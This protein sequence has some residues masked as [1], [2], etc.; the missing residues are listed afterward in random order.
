[1]TDNSHKADSKEE[2][3]VD[4]DKNSTSGRTSSTRQC[5][6]GKE[7]TNLERYTLLWCDAQVNATDDNGQ[8][9][10]ELR[11]IINFF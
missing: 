2:C 7:H 5:E 10:L 9:Q 8:M 11:L 1:M 4:N 6:E 3:F